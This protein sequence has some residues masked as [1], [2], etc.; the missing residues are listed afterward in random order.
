MAVDGSKQQQPCVLLQ[1]RRKEKQEEE[2]R[3]GVGWAKEFCYVKKWDAREL[4]NGL[5]RALDWVEWV[6]KQ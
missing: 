3:K 2:K 4:F 5:G 6:G 1:G